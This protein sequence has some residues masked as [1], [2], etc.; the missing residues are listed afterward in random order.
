MAF[1]LI[2]I[3]LPTLIKVSD[4]P[5][6][7][8]FVA[9]RFRRHADLPNNLQREVPIVSTSNFESVA[10]HLNTPYYSIRC[11]RTGSGYV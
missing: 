2:P 11:T 7:F 4:N 5:T 9:D 1:P 10:V 8:T 3:P 6:A